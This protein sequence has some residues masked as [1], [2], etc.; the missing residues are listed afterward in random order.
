MGLFILIL[1]LW[2]TFSVV[3]WS[4]HNGIVPMPTSPRVKKCLLSHL[5]YSFPQNVLELGSGWG[6]LA[7]SLARH[8]PY[9]QVTGYET[10]PVPYFLS[11]FFH[12]FLRYPHLTFIRK[13]FF[14]VNFLEAHLIVCYL[15]PGAMQRLKEK[16]EKELNPGAVLVTHT[17]AIPGWKPYQVVEV[18]DL[19]HTKIYFYKKFLA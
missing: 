15:Y 5:P 10:S 8:Y 19:Y 2:T 17:F 12:F 1:S 7:F 6:N 3:M 18:D 16:L 14:S 9:S 11:R 13:D 4:L